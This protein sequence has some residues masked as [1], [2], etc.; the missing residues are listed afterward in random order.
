MSLAGPGAGNGLG[1]RSLTTAVYQRVRAEIISGRLRQDEKIHLSWM[2][3][4]YGVSLSVVR[5]ALSRLVADGLVIAE[6]QRGF[7]VSPISRDDLLDLTRTRIGIEG[8]AIEQA[9]VAGDSAWCERVESAYRSMLETG[10]T[11]DIER[12]SAAHASFHR[13]LLEPCDSAWLMRVREML[14]EQSE[15]YRLA[16]VSVPL[17]ASAVES[18]EAEHRDLYEAVLERNTAKARSALDAHFRATMKRVLAALPNP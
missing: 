11:F 6:E 14:F 4:H 5:E 10:R 12:W 16:S 2:Q 8:M 15:R 3:S 7:R 1:A 9:I 17:A 13:V 18:I